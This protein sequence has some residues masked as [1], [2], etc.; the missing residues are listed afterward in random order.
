MLEIKIGKL[1]SWLYKL[2]VLW[3]VIECNIII[4]YVVIIVVI[5]IFIVCE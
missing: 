5:V 3:Y 4:I 1:K 2:I